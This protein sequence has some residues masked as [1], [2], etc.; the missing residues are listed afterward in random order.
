M[1]AIL[2]TLSNRAV[3]VVELDTLQKQLEYEVSEKLLLIIDGAW[4]ATHCEWEG[5]G[6]RLLDVDGGDVSASHSASAATTASAEL[7]GSFPFKFDVPIPILA[8]PFQFKL[9][10]FL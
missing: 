3:N 8:F 10:T 4:N 6:N 5:T 2:E 7:I 9:Q 1:K